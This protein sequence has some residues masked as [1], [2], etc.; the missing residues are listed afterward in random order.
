MAA[1]V[2][3][4]AVAVRYMTAHVTATRCIGPPKPA[5]EAV[6]VLFP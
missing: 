2:L 6:R 5:F 4:L 1:D 3:S